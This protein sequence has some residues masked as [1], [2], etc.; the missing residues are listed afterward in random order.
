MALLPSKDLHDFRGLG[1]GLGPVAQFL[2]P[3]DAAF[4]LSLV[5]PIGAPAAALSAFE[6]GL[7]EVEGI[8]FASLA[9]ERR[10]LT[11]EGVLFVATAARSAAAEDLPPS[12]SGPAAE[13]LPPGGP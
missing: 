2:A 9:F 6:V 3:S 5:L 8:P 10:A 12:A 7:A 4:C 11:P 1:P 13:S